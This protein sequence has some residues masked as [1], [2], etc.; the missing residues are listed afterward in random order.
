DDILL[1]LDTVFIKPKKL[2]TSSLIPS[3]KKSILLS[4]NNKP[5]HVTKN[6]GD[7]KFPLTPET[8]K[9]PNVTTEGGPKKIEAV[10]IDDLESWLDDML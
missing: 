6:S 8:T 5:T 1:T 2:E 4:I 7:K 9:T 10:T 3:T